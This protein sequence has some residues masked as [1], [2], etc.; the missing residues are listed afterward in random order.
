VLEFIEQV[1]VPFFLDLYDTLGYLGVAVGVAIETFIPLIPSEIILPMAGWKVSQSAA[2]PSVTE[3]LT[4]QPWTIL[5]VMVAAT[6]GATLGSLGIYLIG[7]WGGRP[8]LDRYGRYLRIEADDLDRADAWFARYGEWAVFF[9]RFVPLLRSFISF[10]AGV[11]RMR[12]GRFLVFTALGTIP[13]NLALVVAGWLL[14]ENYEEVA[15]AL[16]PYELPIYIVV[17][18]L[19]LLV[20]IRWI[21]GRGSPMADKSGDP[22]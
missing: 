22:S 17:G 21:R 12:L 2:N 3:W 1:V 9:G 11:A 18:G 4:G 19:T 20:I 5:G 15:E 7:A 14:G 16:S 8:L 10:P 6:L 13:F